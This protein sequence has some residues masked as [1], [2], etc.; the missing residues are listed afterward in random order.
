M[1]GIASNK[2][3]KAT[4]SD[5]SGLGIQI[6]QTWI[7]LLTFIY[8]LTEPPPPMFREVQNRKKD[9]H[10]E[11]YTYSIIHLIKQNIADSEIVMKCNVA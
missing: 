9:G 10:G 8:F 7:E 2:R 11:D 5:Q 4:Q 3:A 1:R 6:G